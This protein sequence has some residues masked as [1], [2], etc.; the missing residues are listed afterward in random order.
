MT[1]LEEIVL[2]WVCLDYERVPSIAGNV[3]ADLGREATGSEVWETLLA[4]LERG[5]V[6]AYLYREETRRFTPLPHPADHDPKQVWWYITE[7][8]KRALC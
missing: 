3:S 6:T 2:E 4:H 5:L 7:A 8:G 1:K